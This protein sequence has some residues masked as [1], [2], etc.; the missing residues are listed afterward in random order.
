[1]GLPLHPIQI[2]GSGTVSYFSPFYNPSELTIRLRLCPRVC[3]FN[4]TGHCRITVTTAQVSRGS[5]PGPQPMDPSS[6][7][8]S[9]GYIA[10][11]VLSCNFTTADVALD[12]IAR[13][14]FV[15]GLFFHNLHIRACFTIGPGSSR[16]NK[17]PKISEYTP[18]RRRKSFQKEIIF[19]QTTLLI[20]ESVDYYTALRYETPPF[21]HV[22]M[23]YISD[24]DMAATRITLRIEGRSVPGS[25]ILGGVRMRPRTTNATETGYQR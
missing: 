8:A 10:S 2:D 22:R 24:P 21:L 9:D 1:M 4:C 15:S 5:L 19:H 11:C 7:S 25:A 18:L 17:T 20:L 6:L 3:E 13:A 12:F 16:R 23:S 14:L